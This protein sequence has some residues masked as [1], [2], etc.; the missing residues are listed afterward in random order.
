[1]PESFFNKAADQRPV[2][3]LKK[4]LWQGCFPVNFVKCQRTSFSQDSSGRHLLDLTLLYLHDLFLII[5]TILIILIILIILKLTSQWSRFCV[6]KLDLS[7]NVKMTHHGDI[8][9]GLTYCSD[10]SVVNFEQVNDGW[11]TSKAVIHRCP[12][13][14]I[15]LHLYHRC[16]RMNHDAFQ[17]SI[18][19]EHHRADASLGCWFENV[20]LD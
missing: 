14:C 3:L 17:N 8:S 2:T 1:M 4:S 7:Q 20:F 16:L 15:V 9:N 12:A 6:L 19:T 11:L 13:E 10:I 5:L 18:F